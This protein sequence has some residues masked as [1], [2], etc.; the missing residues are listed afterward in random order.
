MAFSRGVV[1]AGARNDILLKES[2]EK[3]GGG[4]EGALSSSGA[5]ALGL[6]PPG[7]LASAQ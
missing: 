2:Q 1:S 6:S 3:A 5:E 7:L 4:Q